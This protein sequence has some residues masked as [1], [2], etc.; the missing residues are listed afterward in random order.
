MNREY[1]RW[2]LRRVSRRHVRATPPAGRVR[3]IGLSGLY[4]IREQTDAYSDATIYHYN[5]ADFVYGEHDPVRLGAIGQLDH[6][7][8]TR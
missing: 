5:P 1:R 6:R 3:A 8:R 7:G 2:Y 4:D